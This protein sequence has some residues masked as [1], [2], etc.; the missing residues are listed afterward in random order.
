MA[1]RAS[2]RAPPGKQR[3]RQRGNDTDAGRSSPGKWAWCARRPLEIDRYANAPWATAA[4]SAAITPIAMAA[5]SGALRVGAPRVASATTAA[6]STVTNMLARL[7]TS[8]Q[9]MLRVASRLQC[10]VARIW[11][12][13]ASVT[14]LRSESGRGVVVLI[15]LVGNESFM[16]MDISCGTLSLMG[17]GLA[18]RQAPDLWRDQNILGL[19]RTGRLQPLC[20]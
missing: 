12:R 15:E 3:L 8:F 20:R 11:V 1:A 18:F 9:V 2:A 7:K 16:V 10:S 17:S 14:P 5:A 19:T 4:S 6:E 13:T